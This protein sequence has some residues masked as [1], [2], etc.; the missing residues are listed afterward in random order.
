M[1]S[2]VNNRV[3]GVTTA[4]SCPVMVKLCSRTGPMARNAGPFVL[5]RCLDATQVE[6]FNVRRTLR[7]RPVGPGSHAWQSGSRIVV[8]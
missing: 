3:P 1:E 8:K 5:E 6:S 4:R 2:G 7:N